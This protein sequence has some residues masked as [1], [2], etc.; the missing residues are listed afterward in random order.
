MSTETLSNTT[1]YYLVVKEGG[2]CIM[3]VR[4]YQTARHHM[5]K[6]SILL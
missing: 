1:C 2:F 4:T 5:S 3:S 6:D